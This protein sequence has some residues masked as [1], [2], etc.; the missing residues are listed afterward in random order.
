MSAAPRRTVRARVYAIFTHPIIK[1]RT[2]LQ[3][4]M[5]GGFS[6]PGKSQIESIPTMQV[7]LRGNNSHGAD[8]SIFSF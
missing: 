5:H 8:F 3:H 4:N 7:K 1:S 2:L 6:R